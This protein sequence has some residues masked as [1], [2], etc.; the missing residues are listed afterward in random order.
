MLC[1]GEM[2]EGQH[3]AWSRQFRKS[4]VCYLIFG[5]DKKSWEN[6]AY[7]DLLGRA[8]RWAAQ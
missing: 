1:C 4:R 8:I 3:I 7:V 2:T 5:H 6:P